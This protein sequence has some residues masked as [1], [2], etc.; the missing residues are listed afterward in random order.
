[1]YD[2]LEMLA[3]CMDQNASATKCQSKSVLVNQCPEIDRLVVL[4]RNTMAVAGSSFTSTFQIIYDGQLM[5]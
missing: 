2:I 1:M 5:Y 3:D 4:N